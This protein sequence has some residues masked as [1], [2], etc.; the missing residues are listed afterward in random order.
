[1]FKRIILTIT[2]TILLLIPT[3]EVFGEEEEEEY[4]IYI[5]YRDSNQVFPTTFEQILLWAKSTGKILPGHNGLLIVPADGEPYIIDTSLQEGIRN[6]PFDEQGIQK[7][8][9]DGTDIWAYEIPGLT[10]ENAK[11]LV[12]GKIP[13]LLKKNPPYA[14]DEVDNAAKEGKLLEAIAKAVFVQ[15]KGPDTFDCVGLVEYLLEQVGIDILANW[16]QEGGGQFLP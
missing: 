5:L 3:I 6:I 2:L 12:E 16:Y 9:A 4:E 1:M 10:S 7:F 13:P 15:Q 8:K 14:W 11:K